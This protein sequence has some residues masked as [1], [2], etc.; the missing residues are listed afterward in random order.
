MVKNPKI[1]N[2]HF[3]GGSLC[4]DYIN[5]VHGRTEDPLRDYLYHIF[6]LLEW[7]KIR[8]VI[9]QKLA[10][11]LEHFCERE[12]QVAASFFDKAINFRE[13]LYRLFNKIAFNQELLQQDLNAINT[14]MSK[15]SSF[16]HLTTS[17]GVILEAYDYPKNSFEP[18]LVPLIRDAKDLLLKNQGNRIRACATCGWLYW[19]TS[20]NGKRR[21]C[22]MKMCGSN[23]KA[24]AWYHRHKNN[25]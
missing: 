23:A 17:S 18:L 8:G 6:D 13:E 4:L 25:R 10:G 19:D 2:I 9:A 7:A 14:I 22:S 21:W 12:P 1:Q 24:L 3:V 16:A 15:I 5:T 20:K 11:E